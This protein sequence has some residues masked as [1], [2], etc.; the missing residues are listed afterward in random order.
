MSDSE[1]T[2]KFLK[3]LKV[4][5]KT[6][7]CIEKKVPD[8]QWNKISTLIERKR[9][10]CPSDLITPRAPFIIPLYHKSY[11]QVLF[12]IIFLKS[13]HHHWLDSL[14]RI[15]KLNLPGSTL[16]TEVHTAT[17]TRTSGQI[18]WKCSELS[19]NPMIHSTLRFSLPP[20][21]EW[22]VGWFESTEAT[23]HPIKNDPNIIE[24]L[25]HSLRVQ[26]SKI[27][28]ILTKF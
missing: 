3:K 7:R 12:T 25:L 1:F 16:A 6:F 24:P 23:T 15:I 10:I 8:L 13:I 21:E 5:E 18:Y 9:K 17:I 2:F 27:S 4:Y 14:L 22:Y 19:N 28:R 26:D 11:E 20:D